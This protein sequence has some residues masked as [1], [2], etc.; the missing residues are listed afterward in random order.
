MK[1][2]H[3]AVSTWALAVLAGC[4]DG[5]A[6]GA[7][8]DGTLDPEEVCDDGNT[9]DGDGCSA[10]CQSDETCGN[11][12]LDPGEA[13]DDGNTVAG[14]GC[15][16][17][18]QFDPYCGD[19]NV[20]PGE[21]CDDGNADNG[22]GCTISCAAEASCGDG[23]PDPGEECD[24]GNRDDGD[25][26]SGYCLDE[27]R[28]W[29]G[30]ERVDSGDGDA[31]GATV[32]FDGDGN[33]IAVWPQFDGARLSI[34]ASR[35]RPGLGW[36][37]QE[38]IDDDVV[39][40]ATGP[41]IAVSPGGDAIAVWSQYDDVG[42][43]RV[44]ANHYQAGAGWGVPELLGPV[45][46]SSIVDAVAADA[47]GNMFAVWQAS[48]D[49]LWAARYTGG[50][51]WGTAEVIKADPGWVNSAHIAVDPAGNAFV[52]WWQYDGTRANI[53]GNRYAAGSGWGTAALLE[54]DNAGPAEYPGV[55]V[56]ADGN[57]IAV[58]HQSDGT[59]WNIVANRYT[60]GSG[61][62]SPELLE[63]DSARAG[64]PQIAMSD[65]G[66]ALAVWS[67]GGQFRANH[68]T[69]GSGW[70]SAEPIGPT[71]TTYGAVLAMD[72]R[73]NAIAML[74]QGG[75]HVDAWTNHY[76]AGAGWDVAELRETGDGDVGSAAVAMRPAGNAIAIWSQSD[77]ARYDI[78]ADH[79]E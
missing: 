11:R 57:A 53:W 69:A 61:W 67:Q 24:D 23:N 64:D 5:G 20:D 47:D 22:D 17:T 45:D 42:Y 18:C 68:Y 72:A 76:T 1:L 6:S 14:D 12:I 34:W 2:S 28:A 52:V 37:A 56:D 32:A 55:A 60:A 35:Y 7:C 66:D 27:L 46:Y 31:S 39:G 15:G 75:T 71:G 33:A 58:W 13:C 70:G 63:T 16:V 50:A 54:T 3:I 40:D 30:P 4:G 65:A 44:W 29:V 73:G 43:D 19:G 8:G 10:S 78:W 62:G 74:V 25:G 77:G 26:C 48:D 36:S 51:G 21:G 38:V 79:Y 49:N 41:Q 59:A 9:V